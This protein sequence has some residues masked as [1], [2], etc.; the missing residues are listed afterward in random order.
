MTVSFIDSCKPDD[1]TCILEY[2]RK[3][4]SYLVAR[5]SELGIQSS[6]SLIVKNIQALDGDLKLELNDI[7]IR[8][9]KK[10]QTA[11]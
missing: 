9:I 5:L 3:A 4:F 10:L 6:D 8:G 1:Q 2:S 11:T 7:E